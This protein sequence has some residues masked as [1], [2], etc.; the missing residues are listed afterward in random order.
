[1][2]TFPVCRI[3]TSLALALVSMPAHGARAQATR[4]AS[5]VPFPSTALL[6]RPAR[7]RVRDVPLVDALRELETRSGVPL[8][9][10][11]SLLPRRTAV[12][13]PCAESTIREALRLML[14]NSA[15]T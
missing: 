11:P 10:S 5:N 3:A 6:D 14:G 2:T 7:L 9:Y 15:F 13:C 4:L 8:A 12:S 1:M